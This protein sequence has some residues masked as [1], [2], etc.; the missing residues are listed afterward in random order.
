MT[1]HT[2]VQCFANWAVGAVELSLTVDC[3]YHVSDPCGSE[4][5]LFAC[6]LNM[7]VLRVLLHILLIWRTFTNCGRYEY[8]YCKYSISA[9]VLL[10]LGLLSLLGFLAFRASF[11]TLAL[12]CC[13]FH[14]TLY[15]TSNIC[16]LTVQPEYKLLHHGD[17]LQWIP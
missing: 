17:K 2:Q 9:L 1:S 7:F 8:Q 11:L 12:K 15:I 13:Y 3:C 5:V 6:L 10:A 14:S 4:S 16:I